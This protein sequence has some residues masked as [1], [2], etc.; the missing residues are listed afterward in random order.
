MNQPNRLVNIEQN[1]QVSRK[2]KSR[3]L[4]FLKNFFLWIAGT[5][6]GVVPICLKQMEIAAVENYS[7]T[8]QLYRMVLSDFDFSFISINAVFVLFLEGCLLNDNFLVWKSYLR[9]CVFTCLAALAFVYIATFS[10]RDHFAWFWHITQYD[11]NRITL[12]LAVLLGLVCH[13]FIAL[14]KEETL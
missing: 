11:Y 13:I 9:I 2:K 12:V 8:Y 10:Y 3:L 5:A 4:K 14:R 7:G 1:E 6:V